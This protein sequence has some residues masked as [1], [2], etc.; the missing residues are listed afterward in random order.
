MQQNAG[1]PKTPDAALS[2][3]LRTEPHPDAIIML[4][5]RICFAQAPEVCCD[6]PYGLSADIWSCGATFLNMLALQPPSAQSLYR[7]SI[8]ALA[9]LGESFGVSFG[10]T[11]ACLRSMLQVEPSMRPSSSQLVQALVKACSSHI[12]EDGASQLSR[13]T[14]ERSLHLA[15]VEFKEVPRTPGDADLL[16]AS[17]LN[18]QKKACFC[19]MQ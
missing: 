13:P 4:T 17:M 1:T 12:P 11:H 3:R 8:P 2:E 16:E 9:H 7:G 6:Q 10:E 18:R 5:L 15:K 19:C 14:S